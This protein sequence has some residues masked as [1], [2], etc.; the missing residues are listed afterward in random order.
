MVLI[1]LNTALQVF[2]ALDFKMLCVCMYTNEKD[3]RKDLCI[4]V[5]YVL[6]CTRGKC[7]V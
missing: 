3:S 2:K 1:F 6:T 5:N 7:Y 4:S